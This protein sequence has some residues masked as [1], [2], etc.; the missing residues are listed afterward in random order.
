[1]PDRAAI[2]RFN[3]QFEEFSRQLDADIVLV[4]KLLVL[5][6][7]R[8]IIQRSPVDT[9]RFRANWGI[10]IGAPAQP[11]SHAVNYEGRKR[12]KNRRGVNS[13]RRSTEAQAEKYAI[14]ATNAIASVDLPIH[15]TNNLPYAEAIENGHSEQALDGVVGPVIQEIGETLEDLLVS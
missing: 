9:V 15:I 13:T 8:G 11:P 3:S 6:I 14:S 10:A 5:Q 12:K 7:F 4:T 2:A 1:M